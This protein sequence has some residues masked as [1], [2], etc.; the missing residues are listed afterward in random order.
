LSLKELLLYGF[1]TA[2]SLFCLFF[3]SRF[4]FPL[5][6]FYRDASEARSITSP[7]CFLRLYA[8]SASSCV[9]ILSRAFP[10]ASLPFFLQPL[11]IVIFP[12]TFTV[13]AR[14]EGDAFPAVLTA[15]DYIFYEVI[16][17]SR[18]EWSLLLVALE[19]SFPS[20]LFFSLMAECFSLL[21]FFYCRLPC[22]F[23][24]PSCS[25]S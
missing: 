3:F 18:L 25:A 21:I 1:P 4:A 23:A 11:C 7:V 14:A 12:F 19:S 24:C 13:S 15:A 10:P 2:L 9:L 17:Q 5:A 8:A 22:C 16:C 6:V 20:E